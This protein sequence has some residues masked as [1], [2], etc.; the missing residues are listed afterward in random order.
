M[1]D[2]TRAATGDLRH[3]PFNSTTGAE[4]MPDTKRPMC[5][6]TRCDNEQGT[7]TWTEING[8]TLPICEEHW[9]GNLDAE[10]RRLRDENERLRQVATAMTALSKR[11]IREAARLVIDP[12]ASLDVQAV[13]DAEAVLR[14]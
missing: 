6:W 2:L 4:P 9:Y 12:M 8:E 3:H 5:C 1:G 14:G 7:G 13:K 11:L 10:R